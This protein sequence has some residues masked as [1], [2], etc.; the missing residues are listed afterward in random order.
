MH[1]R[2]CVRCIHSRQFSAIC[3]LDFTISPCNPVLSLKLVSFSTALKGPMSWTCHDGLSPCS[4]HSLWLLPTVLPGTASRMQHMHC[5]LRLWD[6]PLD[7]ESLDP[8]AQ[9]LSGLTRLANVYR[10]G[11][12]FHSHQHCLFPKV[13]NL[14]DLCQ[15]IGLVPAGIKGLNT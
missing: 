5:V 3:Y 14:P 12:D 4:A 10:N 13:I 7:E 6:Q 2:V 15:S 8:R 11:N 1:V 9:T